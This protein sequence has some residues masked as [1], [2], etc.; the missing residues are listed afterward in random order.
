MCGR[1]ARYSS[2]Q[3]IEQLLGTRIEGADY[4]RVRYNIGPGS[5]EWVIKQPMKSPLPRFEQL[6]WG[7]LNPK[8]TRWHGHV[9]AETAAAKLKLRNLLRHRRCVV[10]MDGYY[11]WTSTPNGNVPV[12][13]HLK[14]G[15]PFF[16]AALWDYWHEG[17]PDAL[18]C[19]MLLTINA[20]EWAVK[21]YKTMPVILSARDVARWLDPTSNELGAVDDL[22][23][24]Y[25]ASHMEAYPV[26]GRVYAPESEGPELIRIDN[27]TRSLVD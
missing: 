9:T 25:P 20:N 22:V 13:F 1:Y 18:G 17:Q 24:P 27:A 11:Q 15:E 6:A 10:A 21:Y 26:S 4:L 19:Y 3:R 2:K 7:L 14:N 23:R 12:W 16:V 8:G 5:K